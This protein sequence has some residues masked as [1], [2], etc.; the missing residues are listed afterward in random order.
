MEAYNG[1]KGNV[2]FMSVCSGLRCSD[3]RSFAFFATLAAVKK[4]SSFFHSLVWIYW[5]LSGQ[6]EKSKLCEVSFLCSQTRTQIFSLRFLCIKLW[7]DTDDWIFRK[8]N[9]TRIPHYFYKIIMILIFR[10]AFLFVC[11]TAMEI[12]INDQIALIANFSRF[13]ET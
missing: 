11:N 7:K 3:I 6:V 1:L 8:T 12:G 9:K 5:T 4:N 13:M 10:E 2:F